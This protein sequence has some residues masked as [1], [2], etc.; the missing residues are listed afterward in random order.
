MISV[1]I[2][3]YNA[4]HTIKRCI[5]S[6]KKQSFTDYETIVVNDVYHKGPAATRNKGI[7]QAKGEHIFFLDA[8]DCLADKDALQR[9]AE[10]S[11]DLVISGYQDKCLNKDVIK[12]Y[13]MQYLLSPNRNTEFAFCWG[14]LFKTNIIKK[15]NIRFN[16]LM[17]KHED[18]QF[19]F[20][21]LRYCDTVRIIKPK[22]V[23]HSF[24]EAG[25]GMEIFNAMYERMVLNLTISQI[26][27]SAS[28]EYHCDISLR[29]V[30]I[31]RAC[32]KG[33]FKEQYKFVEKLFKGDSLKYYLRFKGNSRIIPLLLRLRFYALAVLVCRFKARARYT[34][35][36]IFGAGTTG[37][38]LLEFCR[39]KGIRVE[40]FCDE[41][42]KDSFCELAVFTPKEAKRRFPGAKYMITTSAVKDVAKKLG[43]E[44]IAYSKTVKLLKQVTVSGYDKFCLDNC[45]EANQNY[46]NDSFLRSLDLIITEKCTL[47]CQDCSNLMQYYDK[48]KDCNVV[49][50]LAD[51]DKLL[52]HYKI[53]EIRVIGGEPF[54]NKNWHTLVNALVNNP[55]VKRIV[56]YTNG[57][58]IPWHLETLASKKVLV[59]ITNYGKLS[60]HL[61]S[62][63]GELYLACVDYEVIQPIWTDCG[64]IEKHNRTA[65][66][67]EQM[68]DEC[69]S[70]NMTLSDGKLYECAF[71]ANLA[72]LGIYDNWEACDYCNGRPFNAEPII[73]AIQK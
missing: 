3:A 64:K 42:I 51:L 72:R 71:S 15:H 27:N 73:P 26:T 60:K 40:C 65:Q 6:V 66:E 63:A 16:V 56:I 50:I 49:E 38:L 47:K 70:K 41:Q 57:T 19:V 44:N 5:D 59:L 54:M 7:E 36:I 55:K 43:G 11:G 52:K 53:G 20:H 31:I 23:L 68:F 25:K 12:R 22:T 14:K 9:L 21:Y 67:I 10:C 29:I 46:D 32:R 24:S 61:A 18:T 2:P 35:L 45:I 28:L 1:I 34:P 17:Q 48:P 30:D 13:T 33:S 37:K 4:E 69:C 39:L 62:L 58:I 8:D